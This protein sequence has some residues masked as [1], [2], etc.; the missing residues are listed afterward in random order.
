MKTEI[1]KY[2]PCGD[3]VEYRKQFDSF[4]E[5]WEQCPRGDWMLW[6]AEKIGVDLKTI[7][8]AKALCANTVKHLM[9]DKLSIHAINIAI[10]FGKNRA[11]RKELD[12]ANAA[13]VYAAN[14][15]A[16]AANAAGN[17]AA[18]AA[19]YAAYTAAY[20][21]HAANATANATANA[22]AYAAIYATTDVAAAKKKNQLETANICKLI[23]TEEVF[24][25]L[26]IK[27]T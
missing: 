12:A 2:N 23:L 25:I 15:A 10:E 4:K 16:Y 7:T 26:K 27:N 1:E 3:A 21:A 13:A 11:T 8:L 22:A 19:A 9:E 24:K 5:A 20:V 14:A 17:A 6:L 18:Y